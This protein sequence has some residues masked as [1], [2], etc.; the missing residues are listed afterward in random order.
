MGNSMG[1]LLA[2][3]SAEHSAHELM[4]RAHGL[5][6]LDPNVGVWLGRF[7][8][9]SASLMAAGFGVVKVTVWLLPITVGVAAFDGLALT[10]WFRTRR[11]F[12]REFREL[13]G[14][15]GLPRAA[16]EHP[17]PYLRRLGVELTRDDVRDPIGRWLLGA[18]AW[19]IGSV[20]FLGFLC[21]LV[22]VFL[23]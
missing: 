13:R 8:I 18:P 21:Q 6:V 12:L 19:V 5:A 11:Q 1:C 23:R 22:V 14:P 4:E 2:M 10:R 17:I 7:S 9:G 16:R 15:L 3:P 20:M